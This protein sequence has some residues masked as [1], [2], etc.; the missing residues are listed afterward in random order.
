LINIG[1]W[2]L[3]I[4][5]KNVFLIPFT[6]I[7]NIRWTIPVDFIIFEILHLIFLLKHALS[8]FGLRINFTGKYAPGSNVATFIES[9]DFVLVL[10]ET[11]IFLSRS[12]SNKT[13]S[14]SMK[15][16]NDSYAIVR[17]DVGKSLIVF[18]VVKKVVLAHSCGL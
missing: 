13:E 16:R 6:S 15:K 11:Q 10:S 2:I 17:G 8:H 12:H 14:G 4:N 7:S 9:H 18:V 5:E 3:L 1:D